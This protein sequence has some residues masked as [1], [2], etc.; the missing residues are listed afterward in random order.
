MFIGF[1]AFLFQAFIDDGFELDVV[2]TTFKA[3]GCFEE[4]MNKEDKIGVRRTGEVRYVLE[5][6]AHVRAVE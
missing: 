2:V 1:S 5:M 3:D 4:G 6:M